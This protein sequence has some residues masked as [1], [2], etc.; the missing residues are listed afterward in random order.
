M[1]RPVPKSVMN[2]EEVVQN[3]QG[4]EDVLDVHG[5]GGERQVE[6]VE[7]LEKEQLV[8]GV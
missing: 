4:V 5:C 2:P 8:W 3:V 1:R 7:L 6:F